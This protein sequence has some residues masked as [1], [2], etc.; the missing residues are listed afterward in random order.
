MR[1]YKNDII[2]II[3]CILLASIALILYFTLQKKE[4]LKVAVYFEKELVEYLDLHQ[5]TEILINSVV[6][7][8][9]NQEVQVISS[10]CKDQICVHQGRIHYAG[11]T[12][13]CL[14]QRV[15]IKIEGSEVAFFSSLL[16][17]FTL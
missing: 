6:V 11:Q 3:G 5:D 14:P 17:C 13:T 9:Q 4:N 1:K 12:I 16:I 2:L 7:K 8:I 15:F 10:D